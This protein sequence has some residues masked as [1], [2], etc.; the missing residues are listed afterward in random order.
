[1]CVSFYIGQGAL[2]GFIFLLLPPTKK[3]SI[4]NA[5][6]LLAFSQTFRFRESISF[7]ERGTLWPDI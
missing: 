6:A 5:R 3:K 7:V 4:L 2:W 1:M